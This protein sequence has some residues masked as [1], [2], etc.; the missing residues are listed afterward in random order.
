LALDH[1]VEIT[2]GDW[3]APE[4]ARETFGIYAKRWL[5]LG[6][7]RDGNPLSPTT[8]ELYAILWRKWLEPTFGDIALGDLTTEGFRTWLATTRRAHPGST[9]PEKAYRLARTI[10]NVAVDDEKI[11][12]NPCRVKGADRDQSPEH[13]IAMPDDVLR[14]AAAIAHKYRALVILGAWC[15]LRFGELAGLRRV[16]VDLRHRKIHAVEQAVELS[17]GRVVFKRPKWESARD[18]D[19]PGEVVEVLEVHLSEH[20]KAEPNSLLFTSPEGHPLRRTKF[21]PRW[22]AA[23]VTVGIE[24]LHFHDLRGSE[25]PGLRTRAR[26][27]PSSWIARAIGPIPL[28]SGTSTQPA[29][30][31][32]KSPIDSGR[33]CGQP[34]SIRATTCQ[35]SSQTVESHYST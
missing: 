35:P 31:G 19:V 16:N 6:T 29:S 13:P 10:L 23:C 11:R 21:R 4:P 7:G 2:R 15:S 1:L 26:L 9:Q 30:A 3:R 25:P 17:G 24:G 14:I 5:E 27:W 34:R 22:Q 8:A 20:V 28:R 33:S 32:G 12:V 18:V